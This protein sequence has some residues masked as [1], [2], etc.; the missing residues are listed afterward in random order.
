VRLI[1]HKWNGLD[2]QSINPFR[3][4]TY[5]AGNNI[6]I[7][8]PINGKMAITQVYFRALSSGEVLQNYMATK[9]RFG[10]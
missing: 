3:V 10:L 2:F 4:G 8:S 9:S 7:T 1:T 6:D 5:T